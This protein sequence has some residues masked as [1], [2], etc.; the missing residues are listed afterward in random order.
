MLA[1]HCGRAFGGEPV[2]SRACHARYV[3]RGGVKCGASLHRRD[4]RMCLAGRPATTARSAWLRAGRHDGGGLIVQASGTQRVVAVSDAAALDLFT[5]SRGSGR[6]ACSPRSASPWRWDIAATPVGSGVKE[7]P[8]RARSRRR[9]ERALTCASTSGTRRTSRAVCRARQALGSRQLLEPRRRPDRRRSLG[10]LRVERLRRFRWRLAGAA[11]LGSQPFALG[12]SDGAALVV[13]AASSRR[14]GS[15]APGPPDRSSSR[16]PMA[17]RSAHNSCALARRDTGPDRARG[18]M[19]CATPGRSRLAVYFHPSR[20]RLGS[21]ASICSGAAWRGRDELPRARQVPRRAPV[22]FEDPSRDRLARDHAPSARIARSGRSAGPTPR[23]PRLARPR[24]PRRSRRLLGGDG[25]DVV[26]RQTSNSDAKRR[27]LPRRISPQ[28]ARAAFRARACAG[29]ALR[30]DAWVGHLQRA[31]QPQSR[32]PQLPRFRRTGC[33]IVCPRLPAIVMPSRL[34]TALSS[35]SW[36]AI[37]AAERSSASSRE[38]SS[39]P[40]STSA[41]MARHSARQTHS[42]CG[43]SDRRA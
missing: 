8:H 2:A 22:G 42:A 17:S 29:V 1:L 40:S 27:R 18:S 6:Q 26:E 43:G 33:A 4:L 9:A 23:P 31:E 24:R 13:K 37:I 10:L 32:Q 39:Q 12:M 19:A 16:L 34:S 5:P 28:R 21:I 41:R 25:G 14:T 35:A 3:A 11:L 15:S 36:S 7:R 20:I 30:F 38:S